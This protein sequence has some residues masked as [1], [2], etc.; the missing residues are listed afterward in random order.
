MSRIEQHNKISRKTIKLDVDMYK[1]HDSSSH[2]CLM[3]LFPR[4][5]YDGV[6]GSFKRFHIRFYLPKRA[7]ANPRVKINRIVVMINGFDE[8]EYF[9]LYD[10]LGQKL[11]EHDI[12]SVL[13]PLPDH[14]NR[15]SMYRKRSRRHVRPS[16]DLFAHPEM[17]EKAY[18]QAMQEL[19][20]LVDHL[21]YH[22]CG[23]KQTCSF[24]RH[25]FS[26]E[27]K[28]S[29]LGYSMGSLIALASYLDDPL[30]Y[31]ACF[32]LNGGMKLSDL[33]FPPNMI[34]QKKWESFVGTL[35]SLSIKGKNK[36]PQPGSG[37]LQDYQSS[38]FRLF[39]GADPNTLKKKLREKSR[40]ILFIM[41]KGYCNSA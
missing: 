25:L 6:I 35:S 30:V 37:Q 33:T 15:N 31:N 28:V 20:V 34:K 13:L 14:L 5:F 39:L 17:A 22:R 7:V 19:K 10:Q 32:V 8:V 18:T 4:C 21:H 9:T 27:T 11:S 2:V 12:A 36:G 23:N 29:L 3:K 40:R 1:D 24:Y 38:F 26:P 16:S 41:G